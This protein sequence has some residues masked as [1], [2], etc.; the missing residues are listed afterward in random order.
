M[1]VKGDEP[2]FIHRKVESSVDEYGNPV[3]T[4]EEIL[5]RDCLF[6]FGSTDEPVQVSRNPLDAK[7]TVVFPK[8]VEILDGDEFEIRETMWVKDGEA[9]NWLD[10]FPNMVTGIVVNV[11][12]R[13]G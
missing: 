5:V 12:R 6:W 7:L 10:V 13:D 8:S 4:Q 1:I 9:Q 3:Y 2:I 11:R